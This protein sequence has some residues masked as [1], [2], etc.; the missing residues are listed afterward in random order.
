MKK[1][2]LSAKKKI[3][4][5]VIKY[6]NNKEFLNIFNEFKKSLNSK[7]KYAVAVSGLSLIHI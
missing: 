6:L 3:P 7:N 5:L 4:K 2:S 1:K